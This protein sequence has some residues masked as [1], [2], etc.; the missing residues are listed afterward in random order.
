MCNPLLATY[1]P[2]ALPV[3]QFRDITVTVPYEGELDFVYYA[4]AEVRGGQTE[5]LYEYSIEEGTDGNF[6]VT[7][8]HPHALRNPTIHMDRCHVLVYGYRNEE[9][10]LEL[11]R[12]ASL[13]F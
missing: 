13:V 3:P 2:L 10:V 4:I 8:P 12:K 5:I 1:H 11:S 6:N 9:K 7:L